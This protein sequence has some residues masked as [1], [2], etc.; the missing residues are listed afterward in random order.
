MSAP[1]RPVMVRRAPVPEGATA[2]ELAG[3]T[4]DAESLLVGLLTDVVRMR[5]P[6][7]CFLSK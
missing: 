2:M 3:T 1:A 7:R 5:A 6:E 4:S